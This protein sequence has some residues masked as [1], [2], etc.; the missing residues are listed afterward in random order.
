MRG[1]IACIKIVK[2]YGWKEGMLCGKIQKLLIRGCRKVFF[3]FYYCFVLCSWPQFYFNLFFPFLQPCC[4]SPLS[5]PFSPF[6]EWR[7]ESEKWCGGGERRT[8]T[9]VCWPI[10]RLL[11][12]H[13]KT[14]RYL[15][16][17]WQ[18]PLRDSTPRDP[19]DPPPF[20]SCRFPSFC[21]PLN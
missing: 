3:L 18:G 15:L 21:S 11:F 13:I 2:S 20:F 10:N 12:V 1:R 16:T 14:H 6:K 7:N 4:P 8:R 19:A 5:Q 17:N 9:P